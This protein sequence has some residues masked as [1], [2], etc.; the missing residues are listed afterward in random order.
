MGT[1]R[2][3]ILVCR[4]LFDYVRGGRFSVV[5]VVELQVHLL[6]REEE[7][8]RRGGVGGVTADKAGEKERRRT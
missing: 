3:W 5:A 4:V 1:D 2:N 6:A 8:P 7:F